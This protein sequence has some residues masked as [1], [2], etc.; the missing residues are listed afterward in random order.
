MSKRIGPDVVRR[1][2]G[3]PTISAEDI[4]FPCN[5]VLFFGIGVMVG[6]HQWRLPWILVPITCIA[7]VVA[8]LATVY[9]MGAVFTALGRGLDRSW[10]HL[11]SACGL[12]GGLSVALLLTLP[13]SY[14]HRTAMLCLAFALILFSM[15]AHLAT[16]RLCL[17][18]VEF[19]KIN[20][21]QKGMTL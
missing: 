19:A 11:L 20:P 2:E 10:L 9:P 1:W 16:D 17:Q 5:T 4:P 8:R 3:N 6:Q 12:R 7:L 15:A 13:A 14:P 18:N 21:S